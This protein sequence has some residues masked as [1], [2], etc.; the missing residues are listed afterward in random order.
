MIENN[1]TL[2]ILEIIKWAAVRKQIYGVV[3]YRPMNLN[4]AEN[5]LFQGKSKPLLLVIEYKPQSNQAKG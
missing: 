1:T 4:Q 2:E 5:A 3:L